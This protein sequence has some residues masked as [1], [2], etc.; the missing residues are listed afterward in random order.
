MVF[1]TNRTPSLEHDFVP[2][3][4]TSVADIHT[5]VACIHTYIHTYIHTSLANIHTSSANIHTSSAN[6][7]TCCP[8]HCCI[9]VGVMECLQCL[10]CS[11]GRSLIT[12]RT[13]TTA[14]TELRSICTAAR[15]SPHPYPRYDAA[16]EARHCLE[17]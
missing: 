1:V 10:F 3:I 12:L 13:E 4:N 5:S 6:I 16:D 15:P 14:R 2:D 7:H 11:C 17:P 8:S 9:S